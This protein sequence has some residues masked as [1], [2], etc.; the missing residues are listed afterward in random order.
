MFEQETFCVKISDTSKFVNTAETHIEETYESEN[1]KKVEEI[2]KVEIEKN[3]ELDEQKYSFWLSISYALMAI[4]SEAPY[5]I[6]ISMADFFK[7]AFNVS[8]VMINEFAIME[9]IIVIVVCVLLHLIGSYRLKW[10]LYQPILTVFVLGILYLVILFKRDHI[11]HKIIIFSAIP[12]GFI[13][14]IAK[15]TTIKICVLFKKPYCSAYVCGLSLSGF[16]VFL[17]YVLGA[18]VLFPNDE[19]KFCNMFSLFCG[20]ISLLSIICFLILFKIYN[21]PFVKRLEEKYGDKG[22]LINK[23]IL[24]DS[25]QSLNMIWKYMIVGFLTNFFTYQIYPSIFPTSV[26]IQKE[27]K[28]LLSGVLLFGDSSARLV[29]HNLSSY[30]IKISFLSY[31]CVQIFRFALLPIFALIVIYKHYIL[32]NLIFLIFLAYIF[33][34]TNG[35]ISN[36]VFLKLPEVCNKKNKREYLQL[37][38]NI[39]YLSL[40]LGTTVG[41]ATSK[42]YMKILPII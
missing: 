41:C 12:L 25:F 1:I 28:G 31:S 17:L 27:S 21:L 9:S 7:S 13:L 35:L 18:Y 5:F 20:T 10:N 37:V 36:A 32:N 40:L 14:C 34:F 16:L 15:M 33:G 19:N 30:F 22:L 4:I 29:V 39:V 8:D 6:I 26:D 42:I 2:Y 38:P 11:G 24:V 3:D 23:T